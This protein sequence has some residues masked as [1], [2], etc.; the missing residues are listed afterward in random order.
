MARVSLGAPKPG[1]N[2]RGGISKVAPKEQLSTPAPTTS[3]T[4]PR[5]NTSNGT[6]LGTTPA[7]PTSPTIDTNLQLKAGETPDTY[8]SRVAAY[9]ATKAP[10]APVEDT[11]SPY[12][13]RVKPKTAAESYLEGGAFTTPQTSEQIAREK[14]RG[15]QG[16][17]DALNKYGADLIQTQ[18]QTNNQRLQDTNSINALTGLAGSSEAAT[19]TQQ[20]RA[21]NTQ[22]IQKIQDQVSVKVQGILSQIRQDATTEAAQQRADA[23]T[24]AKASIEYQAQ[25]EE[26]ASQHATTLAASG[27]TVDGL[28]KT[29]PASYQ[30]LADSV[31]GEGMLKALFTLNRPQETIIDK[32]IEGGKYMVA[33]QNPITGKISIETLDTGLPVGYSNTI[34]AGNRILAVPDNWD[35]DPS[36]LVTINKGLTPSQAASASGGSGG[37]G[38]SDTGVQVSSAAQNIIDQINL[39]ANLDDLIKGTSNAAQSLR[40]EVLAGL[41]AQGGMTDKNVEILTE[42]KT[43]VDSLLSTKAYKAMGG[44]STLIGGQFSTSYGDAQAKAGQLSA[45]LARDNLGL[46]KGAMSDKDLAFIQSMSSGFEGAG[47]QSE[48]F[49]KERLE[50][51]Q[52][53][54]KKKID[55]QATQTTTT[56]GVLRSPDGTQEVNVSDLSPEELQ[57]ARDDGWTQ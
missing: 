53:K 46:L 28:K 14:I 36:K 3:G 42:G 1:T 44:Y 33:Y 34:D 6:S 26:K 57:E 51:I 13:P 41:N 47:T 23:V 32:K 54:L 8:N 16:E 35:G 56:Q 45:I 11:P 52:T 31:G 7:A 30:R 12:Y 15:A 55:S 5:K 22:D 2:S 50:T 24:G 49:I 29:D 19:N 21:Q 39:G 10:E 25:R 40:N 38:A 18:T 9:R 20:T 4:A 48:G 37:G 43:V 17:I 27:V